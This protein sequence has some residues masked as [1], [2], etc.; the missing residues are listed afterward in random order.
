MESFPLKTRLAEIDLDALCQFALCSATLGTPLCAV[1]VS[2]CLRPWRCTVRPRTG[3]GRGCLAGSK[4]S[5]RSSAA[6][7]GWLTLPILILGHVQPSY[8]SALI[9][10]QLTAA[11]YLLRAGRRPEPGRPGRRGPGAGT[12]ESGH[13]HGRIG[14]ALRTDFDAAIA[15]MVNGCHL[16]GLQVTGLFQHF[17]VADETSADPTAYTQEQ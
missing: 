11:C 15:A 6:A 17:A 1:K 16:P 12:P 2:R 8:A 7:P 9:Q 5:G 13:R 14:F 4:L 10:H 3:P